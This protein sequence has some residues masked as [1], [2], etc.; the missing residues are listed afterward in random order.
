MTRI[1]VLGDDRGHRS[2]QE[3]NA[4]RPRLLEEL[5]VEATWVP[6]ADAAGAPVHPLVRAFAA[7]VSSAHR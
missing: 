4:L 1:A 7:A 2:H 5:G 3:L 6:S